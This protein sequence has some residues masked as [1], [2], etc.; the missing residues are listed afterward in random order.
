MVVARTCPNV[1]CVAPAFALNGIDGKQVS[2]DSFRGKKVVLVFANT[3]CEGCSQ[4]MQCISQVYDAWP[5]DQLEVLVIVSGES[6]STVHE[7]A[8][9]NGLKCQVLQ[10]PSGQVAGLY[11]PVGLPAIYFINTYGEIKVKRTGSW[12]NCAAGID[13]LLKLY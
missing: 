11:K 9:A 6:D 8:T 5:R 13:A 12:D 1:G 4:L 3:S 2:L 7:W 10:D